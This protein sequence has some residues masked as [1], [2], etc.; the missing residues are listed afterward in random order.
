VSTSRRSG[1]ALPH[2][3]DQLALLRWPFPA[4]PGA[5]IKLAQ[6]PEVSG[7]IVEI[8]VSE[9]ALNFAGM[10]TVRG[11]G[12]GSVSDRLDR[13][14][15]AQQ[16]VSQA[17]RTREGKCPCGLILATRRFLQETHI[18]KLT[19]STMNA[20]TTWGA[21]EEPSPEIKTRNL[22]VLRESALQQVERIRV[23]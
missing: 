20:E 8:T 14:R 9:M 4:E 11:A 18:V 13:Q 1:S 21:S 2:L 12:S 17:G 22:S 23:R 15:V 7:L 10:F 19:L 6:Q 16:D 5:R 3:L